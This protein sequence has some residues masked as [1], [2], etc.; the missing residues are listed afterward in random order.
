MPRITVNLFRFQGTLRRREPNYGIWAR[1][2][3][4]MTR[5]DSDIVFDQ[6]A[7]LLLAV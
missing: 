4:M 5:H 3:P 1:P 2:H 6:E 7:Y